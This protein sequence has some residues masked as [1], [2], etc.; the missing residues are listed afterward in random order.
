MHSKNVVFFSLFLLNHIKYNYKTIKSKCQAASVETSSQFVILS[1]CQCHAAGEWHFT[2]SQPDQTRLHSPA[3][4][5]ALST[6]C[7]SP[8]VAPPTVL[9]C[10]FSPLSWSSDV[11]N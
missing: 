11:T 4:A 3:P 10:V 7:T 1:L 2:K 5:S 8:P 6:P 9:S